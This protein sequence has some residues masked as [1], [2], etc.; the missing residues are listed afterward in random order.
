MEH[1]NLPTPPPEAQQVSEQLSDIIRRQMTQA[2]GSIAFSQFMHSCLYTPGLG[3]YSG[4][5]P[6]LGAEG[7]FITA[8]EISPL[9][10]QALAMHIADVLRQLYQPEVLE[11]G[12]GNGTLAVDILQTLAAHDCMPERYLILET[13]ADLRARQSRTL[14]QACPELAERVVWLDALPTTFKGA[15]VANEVC[16]AMPFD[17][18]SVSEAGVFNHHVTANPEFEWI[19]KPIT[20]P[21]LQAR[22]EI[23]QTQV[24]PPYICEVSVQADAWLYSLARCLTAGGV[25]LIDYGYG[26]T[27]LLRPERAAGSLL[28][29]YRHQAHRNPFWYPGL[30]DITADVD[31]TALAETAFNNELTVAGFHYQRDFL[32]AGD[33]ESFMQHTEQPAPEQGAALKQLLMPI[34]MGE[35]FKILTLTRGIEALPRLAFNDRRQQL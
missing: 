10:G 33:I 34:H 19:D 11:F 5:L 31:F 23:I 17:V 13:S 1:E 35:K 32:L 2:G 7:D 12:A 6:K 26:R 15:I 28:C 24:Q 4:P 20:D 22:A 30:Q 8:P 16:D 21:A 3:Y 14:S 18:L 25:F 9:F 27:E 29:H